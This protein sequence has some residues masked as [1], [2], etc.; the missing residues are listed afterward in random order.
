MDP[1]LAQAA[2]V[3]VPSLADSGFG[4]ALQAMA[5]GRPVVA[6]RWPALAELVVDGETGY[7]VQPGS[8]IELAQ[9]TRRLL[10]DA[11]LRAAW[12]LPAAAGLKRFFRQADLPQ[13]GSAL[14]R[15]CG[16]TYS[17]TE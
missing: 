10:G 5:A 8:K 12:E 13:V 7:L 3:W 6:S 16:L 17:R 9:K 1:L 14:Q 11:G 2:V 4:V 15:G